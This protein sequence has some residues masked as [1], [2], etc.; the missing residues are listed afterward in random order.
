MTSVVSL[1]SSAETGGQALELRG[2]AG[3]IDIS[4][5]IHSFDYGKSVSISQL[6]NGKSKDLQKLWRIIAVYFSLFIFEKYLIDCYK[7]SSHFLLH[8]QSVD[9]GRSN[10]HFLIH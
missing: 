3:V 2:S 4:D 8:H 6:I 1:A 5:I 7:I 10:S 9:L